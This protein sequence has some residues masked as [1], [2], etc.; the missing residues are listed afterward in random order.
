MKV[1]VDSKNDKIKLKN[2]ND[3]TFDNKRLKQFILFIFPELPN[4]HCL[5][6]V[7]VAFMDRKPFFGLF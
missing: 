1:F 3:A 4:N 6:I 5:Y 7:F 2:I